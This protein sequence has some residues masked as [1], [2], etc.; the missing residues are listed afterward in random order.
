M[1][2]CLDEEPKWNQPKLC[3]PTAI[4]LFIRASKDS[5]SGIL[6]APAVLIRSIMFS[7]VVGS[8]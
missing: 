2:E 7:R 3:L 6:S 4:H 8:S 5:K 1:Q